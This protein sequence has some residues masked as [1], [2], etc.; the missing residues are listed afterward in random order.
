MCNGAN[1]YNTQSTSKSVPVGGKTGLQHISFKLEAQISAFTCTY[2]HFDLKHKFGYLFRSAS[3]WARSAEALI[4]ILISSVGQVKGFAT[5]YW[6]ELLSYFCSPE[7]WSELRPP[8]E[9]LISCLVF[10]FWGRTQMFSVCRKN[11]AIGRTVQILYRRER[12]K[13]ETFVWK[14]DQYYH[15]KALIYKPRKNKA[16]SISCIWNWF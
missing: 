3:S 2:S 15:W 9:P 10:I 13:D 16:A 1:Q 11:K 7:I 8:S 12:C 5:K 14:S 6:V 4:T